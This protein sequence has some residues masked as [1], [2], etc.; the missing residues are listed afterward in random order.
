MAAM[1]REASHL[2]EQHLSEGVPA[3]GAASAEKTS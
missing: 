2:L 3:P 1:K